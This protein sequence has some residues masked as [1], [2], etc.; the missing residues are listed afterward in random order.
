M[1]ETD[2]L[3]REV[4][5]Q[6]VLLAL[7][8][9]LKLAAFTTVALMAI[10]PPLAWWLARSRS[11][12]RPLIEALSS[13]PIILPPTVVGFYLLLMMAPDGILGR[14]WS[15]LTGNSLAF[16]F[17]GLV[18]GSV[19]YSLPFVVQ[20]LT[21]SF[22][23]MDEKLLEAAAT[24]GANARQRFLKVAIPLHKRTL[25]AAATL[26]FAH[27]VGEFGVILMIGG[28]LPG[29]TRVLSIL[30]FDQVEALQYQSAH[31]TSLLLLCL[32]GV[33]LSVVYWGQRRAPGPARST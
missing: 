18:V 8:V 20:P 29:T 6:E 16:S 23:T 5:S 4:L 14:P 32:A 2:T 7:W 24:L 9:T 1:S 17:S 31:A 19:V 26:G 15:S 30:I 13:L 11:N 25:V 22:R 33:F 12:L 27:T 10:A 28:N 3:F 21:S